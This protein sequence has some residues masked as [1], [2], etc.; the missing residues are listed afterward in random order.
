MCLAHRVRRVVLTDRRTLIPRGSGTATGPLV[1]GLVVR[2]LFLFQRRF[3]LDQPV[4]AC[5]AHRVER[6]CCDR[7]LDSAA[8]L[9]VV[10]AVTETAVIHQVEH[11]GECTLDPVA[12][13]PET[14]SAY[15]RRVDEPP[16]A[17]QRH[18]FGRDRGVPSALIA[19][20][21]RRRRLALGPDE[22]IDER[23]LPDATR[24]EERQR[25]IADRVLADRSDALTADPAREQNR[26]PECHVLK[27]D[28]PGFR[29]ADQVR[30]GQHDHRLGAGIECQD[31]LALQTSGA[32]RRS[33]RVHQEHDVDVRRQRVRHRPHPVERC[34]PGERRAALQHV[35]DSFAVVRCDHPVADRDVG[36]DVAHPQRVG[37]TPRL[38]DRAH[39]RAPSAIEPRHT[40]RR[41]HSSQFGPRP[42]EVE[43]PSECRVRLVECARHRGRTV[44]TMG[45][46][47]FPW[48]THVM[49]STDAG[50]TTRRSI[51]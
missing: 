48:H 17:G 23:R 15:T 14:Q 5:E 43:G 47:G 18:E 50:L 30:L 2:T 51:A 38:V 31:E 33:E 6:P 8:R 49:R 25:P 22:R 32:R 4:E 45:I 42:V 12:G 3:L 16:L 21:D 28:P 40:P 27:R 36:A 39:D 41:A 37:H 24:A 20:A 9:L 11:V 35:L 46:R 19:L 34:A 1:G 13:Q 44:P 29:I 26:N 10:L 7:R